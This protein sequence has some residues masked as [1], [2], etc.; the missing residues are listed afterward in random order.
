MTVLKPHPQGKLFREGGGVAR[1]PPPICRNGCV[2][3]ADIGKTTKGVEALHLPISG[4]VLVDAVRGL[5][6]AR[7]EI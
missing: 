1:T 6:P 5:H 4:K 3:Q 7:G 2:R